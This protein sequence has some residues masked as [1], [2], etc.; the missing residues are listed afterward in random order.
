[1]LETTLFSVLNG[2]LYGMLVFL[3]A[4]GLTLIFSMMGVLNF[5]HASFYMLGAYFGFEISR[6]VGFA[7][8]CIVA[9]LSVGVI[10]A[11]VEHYGLRTVH[12]LGHV[13]ELLFTFGLAFLI[14][15]VVAMIWGR[16]PVD[17]RIPQALN[18]PAFQLLG[19]SYS[20][21]RVFVLLI[22]VSIFLGLLLALNRT[23]MG[24][25]I[26]ASLTH[27]RMV[28]MLGH[29]VPRVFMLVFGIGS[30]LAA[31]AGVIA[32]PILVTSPAMA[33]QL[34]PLLFAI[35]VVGG[36]GSLQG[37]FLASILVGLLQTFAVAMN[38]SLSTALGALGVGAPSAAL[39]QDLWKTTIA[40][41]APTVPYLL[42]V[43]ILIFKPS[44]LMGSRTT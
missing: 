32:G 5:A 10:G 30:A 37:A 20:A 1:M 18:F 19:A 21:F 34:G 9:P 4:S 3:L 44:G 38:V 11:L 36:L 26:R 35:V 41:I 7:T 33:E 15:Q 29:D 42:L 12:R 27:S 40:Q 2:V 6:H 31:L 16:L 8:A 13:A 25:I 28:S 39:M 24:L 22:S 17:Y 23:R 43:L 14:E